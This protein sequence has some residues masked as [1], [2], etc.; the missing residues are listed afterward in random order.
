MAFCTN[1][2]AELTGN[3]CN[4]CGEPSGGMSRQRRNTRRLTN[5]ILIAGIILVLA[6]FAVILVELVTRST[7]PHGE[8]RLRSETALVQ[9]ALDLLMV[10]NALYLV[11]EHTTGPAVNEWSS[12]PTGAGGA[13]LDS[14]LKSPTKNYYC[15]TA[16][17]DVYP[18][19]DD[20]YI[21]RTPGECSPKP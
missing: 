3:C 5:W 18:W 2:G 8:G 20:I 17:G 21:A 14:Y 11:D 1:C 16:E 19:S 9:T 12:E 7:G 4:Q 13:S 10:E 6:L 15:W